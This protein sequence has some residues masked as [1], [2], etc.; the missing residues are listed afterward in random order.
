MKSLEDLFD[1]RTLQR[2][3]P[4]YFFAVYTATT[5]RSLPVRGTLATG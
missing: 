1:I 2:Y 3:A 5:S 4:H